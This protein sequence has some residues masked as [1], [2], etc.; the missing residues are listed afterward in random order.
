MTSVRI[1]CKAKESSYS[2]GEPCGHNCGWQTTFNWG[3]EN[4]LLE[5]VRCDCLVTKFLSTLNHL[6]PD[7]TDSFCFIQEVS[8]TMISNGSTHHW[9]TTSVDK[10]LRTLVQGD[11]MATK[12]NSSKYNIAK[13]CPSCHRSSIKVLDCRCIK[14]TSLLVTIVNSLSNLPIELR[15]LLCRLIVMTTYA[16]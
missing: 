3:D 15:M 14:M 7:I 11:I 16:D 6:I 4:I 12:I 2:C 8:S 10:Y 5:G 13:V 1:F 9:Y